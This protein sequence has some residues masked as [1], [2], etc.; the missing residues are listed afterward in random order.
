[1]QNGRTEQHGERVTCQFSKSDTARRVRERLPQT[2][3]KHS[4]QKG[5]ATASLKVLKARLEFG[6]VDKFKVREDKQQLASFDIERVLLGC[7]AAQK[8]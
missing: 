1:L 3:L 6:A 4:S 2:S 5:V 8:S 7:L